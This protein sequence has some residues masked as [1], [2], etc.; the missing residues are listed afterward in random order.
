MP[1]I[2]PIFIA[3]PL[4]G[5]LAGLWLYAVLHALNKY[6]PEKKKYYIAY[7]LGL[8]LISYLLSSA[9][10]SLFHINSGKIGFPLA[11]LHLNIFFCAII[12][13]GRAALTGDV[14]K[15]VVAYLVPALFIQCV[16]NYY[17]F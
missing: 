3:I 4:T 16:F 6:Y 7:T 17:I 13:T 12:F 14:N 10:F 15:S 11:Q 9:I 1:T 5:T 8:C 2:S